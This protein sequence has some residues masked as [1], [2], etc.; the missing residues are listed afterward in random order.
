MTLALCL[1]LLGYYALLFAFQRRLLY[2]APRGPFAG[3]IPGD[4]APLVLA[5]ADSVA[6]P[7]W[8]LPA[9]TAAPSAVVL[10]HHGNAERAEDWLNEFRTLRRA[11]LAVLVVE[12]PGYGVAEG[13]PTQESLTAASV[14]AYDWVRRQPH[15]AQIAVVAYGRSLGGGVATRL[16]TRRKVDALIL[17]STFTD[18]RSFARSVFA[19]GFLVRDPY[20][21]VSELQGYRGPLLV[22]HGRS[23]EIAPFH[24]GQMLARVVQDAEF[25]AMPCGHNDCARP[26]DTIVAFLKN[27][28]IVAEGLR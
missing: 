26:W 22:L 2:P 27:R 13:A 5:S 7:A 24:G 20:D 8:Y 11:G 17:E 6:F 23:D 28:R 16:A 9:T 1:A 21:N 19:P 18:L 10:F 25:V 3:T 14:E 4:A 15:L 12:Y